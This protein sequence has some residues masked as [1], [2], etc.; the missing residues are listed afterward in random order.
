VRSFDAVDP[1]ARALGA[2]IAVRTDEALSESEAVLTAAGEEVARVAAALGSP[3]RPMSAAQLAAK[4]RG[5][6]GSAL[7]G[8]L[9]DPTR[10]ATDLVWSL[11]PA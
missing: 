6:A 10:P 2:R 5:L 11:D 8:A 3:A 7:D 1:E 9:E 4:V